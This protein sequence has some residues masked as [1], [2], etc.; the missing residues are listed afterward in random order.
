MRG[1]ATNKR[2]G[3]QAQSAHF[4]S[5]RSALYIHIYIYGHMTTG[6]NVETKDFLTKEPMPCRRMPLPM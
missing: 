6:H 4:E 3:R 1:P 2:Q 5:V